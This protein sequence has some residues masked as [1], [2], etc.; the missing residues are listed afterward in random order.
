[1][2]EIDETNAEPVEVEPGPD[3]LRL[4]DSG[5]I[6]PMRGLTGM[7]FALI[8]KRNATTRDDPDAPAG[9]AMQVGFIVCGE[10]KVLA[11][12]AAGVR[13]LNSHSAR[14]FQTV[15]DAIEHRSGF[16]SGAQKSGMDRATHDE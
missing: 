6:V 3:E 5:E 16:G 4:P 9:V 2:G 8:S 10:R 12:E 11:A 13:W 7:E 15:G 14:D 1:M